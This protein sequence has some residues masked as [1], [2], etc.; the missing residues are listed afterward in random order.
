MTSIDSDIIDQDIEYEVYSSSSPAIFDLDKALVSYEPP[1]SDPCGV[2]L[3]VLTDNDD[4][5]DP[6]IFQF[7]SF[8]N[9]FIIV[10]NDPL[11][12][13]TYDLKVVAQGPGSSNNKAESSFRVTLIDNCQTPSIQATSQ[14]D[15]QPYYYNGTASF[16]LNPFEVS[17][18]GCQVSYSCSQ[19]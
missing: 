14:V 15:M 4:L 19:L 16:L 6:S 8:R 2:E 3:K 13:G 9:K 5:L 1:E 18:S 10:S 17:P 7:D 11:A 12:I